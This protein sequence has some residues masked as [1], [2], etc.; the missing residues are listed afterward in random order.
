MNS[1]FLN[2]QPDYKNRQKKS[3]GSVV[4]STQKVK[5]GRSVSIPAKRTALPDGRF[6]LD[7]P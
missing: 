5:H 1:S 4:E 6:I 7:I 2:F 3:V